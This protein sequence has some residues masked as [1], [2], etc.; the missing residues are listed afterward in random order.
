MTTAQPEVQTQTYQHTKKMKLL[1]GTIAVSD[2]TH[3]PPP[4][5]RQ[6][7]IN[8]T[9]AYYWQ[10]KNRT[11]MEYWNSGGGG[12]NVK[13]KKMSEWSLAE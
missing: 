1:Y 8:E 2:P 12:L 11:Y 10:Y 13:P 5:K 7:D 6:N 9:V 3:P 4:S